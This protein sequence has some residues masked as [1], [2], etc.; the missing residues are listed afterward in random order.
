MKSYRALALKELLAQRVT[1]VLILLAIV[2][3]T[4]MTAVIGQ[5]VGVLSAMRQQQ[6]IALGGDRYITFVQMN[7]EQVAALQNDPR[8][9]FVGEYVTLGSVELNSALTLGL[10]EYHEDVTA[11][12]PSYARLKSGRLPEAPQEIALPEDVLQYLGFT[13]E[14]GDTISLSLSKALRHGVEISS[15]NFTSDFVLVGIAESNYLNYTFGGVTGMVGPGTAEALLPDNYFYYNVDIRTFDKKMFQDTIND[16]ISTLSVQELDTLYNVTYL[17]AL[18]IRYDVEKADT[19]LSSQ[20]FSFML[21]AGVMVGLLLLLAAG[22]VIYNILKIAVSQRIKQYGTLRAIGG[23]RGQLYFLVTAQVLLLCIIGIPIGLLL[24]T[25]SAKGIL[26]AATGLL[27]PEIFLV[28]DT[29]ELNRLIAANSSNKGIFLL[30]SAVIT[31]LF[32]FIAAIPAA[33][34][35]AKVSPTMAMA[36]RS[37]KVKRRSRKAKKI[38]SFEAFYARLNLKRN[39]GRTA[40]TILSLVMSITVFIALQGFTALLNTASGIEDAHLGDY[41]I[42]NETVGFSLDTLTAVEQNE[43]VQSVAAIQFSMYLPDTDNQ[44]TEIEI[45]FELQPGETFQIIGLNNS[46]LSL[47][48]SER[49]STEDFARIKAGEVCIVRNPIATSYG[50]TEMPHSNFE[51]GETI[52][53][54]GKEIPIIAAL[55]GFDG[56]VGISNNGFTNG[57]QVIVSDQLYSELTGASEYSE[58][59]PA[60]VDGADREAFDSVVEQLC[61]DIPGT[62][63]LSYE[64]TDR[65]LAESFEQIRLLAWGLILFVALI[66]LL[67][68]INTVYTNIHT[69]VAEIGMQRAIGMS[70]G[71]LYKVFLWEG[72]YYGM[73]AAIIGSIAGYI[74]TIFVEAATTNAIQLVDVPIIPIVEATVLAIG[75]CLLATCIPLRR[76]SKMSIVDSI[77]TVE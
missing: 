47:F 25:L 48:A 60:L 14:L 4:M 49:L 73:I 8:L 29:G 58:I 57:V 11:I 23:K 39:R 67:N 2:L 70:V 72:A 37:I 34:Y 75:A 9:S 69:R 31:L 45:G 15:Y 51:T 20:G 32:A 7:Q 55:D 36:G 24:G 61:R 27:S 30:A 68:I 28:Q 74:C 26:T 10:N 33:R 50:N 63:Y 17:E 71:S 38:R 1:S 6:A 62:T 35:A 66:G 16:L 40:I 42:I 44:V 76:I 56:Y 65:Q 12:Y 59:L 13:G 21:A 18:G 43:M 64:E 53:V 5:S 46:Y 3:S 22:L 77:E 52:S 19:E 54:A 41:S